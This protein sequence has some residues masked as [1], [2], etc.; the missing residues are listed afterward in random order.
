MCSSVATSPSCKWFVELRKDGA[1]TV[2]FFQIFTDPFEV[3]PGDICHCDGEF[4]AGFPVEIVF[5]ILPFRRCAGTNPTHEFF[6]LFSNI[7]CYN[8]LSVRLAGDLT[9]GVPNGHKIFT[10]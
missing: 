9:S 4:I 6:V 2:S 3:L 8:H 7:V 1:V 5:H 10:V